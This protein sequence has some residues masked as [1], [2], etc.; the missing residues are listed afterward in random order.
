MYGGMWLLH[1]MTSVTMRHFGLGMKYKSNTVILQYFAFTFV[2]I[3]I[4]LW[5]WIIVG[6]VIMNRHTNE[7]NLG[8]PSPQQ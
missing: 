2:N 6:V 1:G 5:E 8:E 3:R 4:G 7:S